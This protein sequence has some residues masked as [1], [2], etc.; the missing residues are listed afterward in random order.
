[1]LSQ[2][3][4]LPIFTDL[5]V[6]TF[7]LTCGDYLFAVGLSYQTASSTGGGHY[8]RWTAL[9]PPALSPVAGTQR[10]AGFGGSLFAFVEGASAE[11]G[12]GSEPQGCCG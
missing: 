3:P 7:T 1:M 12:L 4:A 8:V 10:H 6:L 9:Y 11:D 5:S 2:H